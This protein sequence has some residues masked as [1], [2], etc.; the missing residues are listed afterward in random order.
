MKIIRNSCK[1]HNKQKTIMFKFKLSFI[2]AKFQD[3]L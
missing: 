3:K 2:P 1:H